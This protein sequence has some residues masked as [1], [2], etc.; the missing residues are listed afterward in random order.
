VDVFYDASG[1]RRHLVQRHQLAQ[2]RF[3]QA[4]ELAVIRFDG[5]DDCL[6]L[7]GLRK[8]PADLTMFIVAA[9]R[10]NAGYFRCLLSANQTGMNDYTTGFNVD[11][12][13]PASNAV[14]SVNIEGRGF[15][16]AVD[17]LNQILPFGEFHTFAV[18]IQRTP[19]VV[20]LLVDGTETGRRAGTEESVT[21]D[22]LTLGARVYSNSAEPPFLSGFFDGDIAEVLLFDRLLTADEHTS[23]G[24]YFRTKYAQLGRLLARAAD[25]GS[26][27]LEPVKNPPAVQMFVPGFVVRELPL[28]LHNVNNVRYRPDGKLL[29]LS[30][31]GNIHLLSDTDHDGLED[32]AEVFWQNAGQIQSPVGMALTPPNYHLGDG[33]FIA[34]LGKLTLVVDTDRDGR[35]DREIVAAQGWKPL[36]HGVDALGVAVADDQSIYFGLGTADFTNAYQIAADRSA[37]YDLQS[38]RGTV[39]RVAPDFRSRAIVATGIRFPV[40]MAFN[41]RGDLFVTDQEGATWLPNGNPFD[42][43]LHIQAGRHYGFPPRHPRYLPQVIDEP[44]VYDYAP[45]HQSTCGLAFNN[46]VDG[47]PTFGPAMWAGDALVTGYSR[48][49]LYRTKLIHTADG[50]VATNRLFAC[51]NHLPSDLCVSPRGDLVVAVHTGDPDWGSGPSGKGRLYKIEYRQRDLPQPALIYPVSPRELHIAFDRPLQLA[52]LKDIARRIEIEHG[53]FV[54]PGDRFES[55]RPGYAVVGMQ[56]ASPR[57]QLPIRTVQISPDRR[58][59]QLETDPLTARTQCAVTLPHLHGLADEPPASIPQ[60]AAIDLGYDQC[61]VL[62]QWQS[63]DGSQSLQTW[64]PHLNSEVAREFTVGSAAHETFFNALATPG[65]LTLRT[66]LDLTNLLRPQV[67]PGS[68]ID[69][70]LPAE[71]ASVFLRSKSPFEVKTPARLEPMPDASRGT[72][73]RIMPDDLKRPLLVEITLPNGGDSPAL[74]VSWSTAEDPQ[75]RAFPLRRFLLPWVNAEQTGHTLAPRDLS[76]LEGG[77]WLRGQHLFFGEQALCARCHRV[78]GRGGQ[79]GPDLSNLIHRDYDSVLKD[80]RQ[81]SAAINPDHVAYVVE[82]NDD[83]VLTGLVRREAETLVIGDHEGREHT[84]GSD[85]VRSM[86]PASLSIMPEGVDTLLGPERMRDLLTFLLTTPLEPAQR[87]IPGAPPVRSRAEVEAV[88]A[89]SQPPAAEPRK[90]HVVLCAGPKDHGPGEH[91]YPLWQQRWARLFELDESVRV[92]QAHEWPSAEQLATADVIAFYSNN[93]GWSA[94]RATQ[95]DAFLA[96]G[97]G[98]V[99]MHYAVDGHNAAQELARQIGLAWSGRVSKFRHG[100]VDLAFPNPTHPIARGFERVQFE[101]ETYWN[102]VGDPGDIDLIATG[103]EEGRPQPLLWTRQHNKGRVFVSILGHYTWTFDDPLFRILILRGIAWSTGESVD[104]FNELVFPGALLQPSSSA[105]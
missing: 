42:E 24:E 80:I 52:A 35:A 9:P 77:N 60:I 7:S 70:E 34:C 103:I 40:G 29:A 18:E 89:N 21:I 99:Y 11:L 56:L 92:S 50:Y 95:L 44:S 100:A 54:A 71:K 32:H 53:Q 3:L 13:G 98:L 38:E 102:L 28:A 5:Q 101:D 45:Q 88:L 51:L 63:S 84:V 55:L 61:G 68:R 33:V 97:G 39:L 78:G 41:A 16:G 6:E 19:P 43:L 74:T 90:L 105:P 104:R 64:L 23:L 83:R 14:D 2:P 25:D 4:G 8:S 47:G 62:A 46:P 69:Y 59:L 85:E 26:R 67:Q 79:I 31:D 81:P 12:S 1:D 82:L 93:P 30:Y 48:G 58:T 87:E 94:R 96:R 49:K 86:E 66:Q 20:R 37:A 17:L 57:W 73:W 72:A 36:P 91:D 27:P 10:T 22:E 76:Q 65:Q 75:W 15:S